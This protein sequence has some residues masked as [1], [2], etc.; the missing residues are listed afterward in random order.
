M[1][2]SVKIWLSIVYSIVSI[3]GDIECKQG[4]QSRSNYLDTNRP[5]K[6]TYV[7]VFNFKL[8]HYIK[9]TRSVH[10]S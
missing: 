4:G 5:T 10:S 8:I 1:L 9:A 6:I 7:C 2:F 3:F